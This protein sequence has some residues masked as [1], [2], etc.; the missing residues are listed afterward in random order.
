MH[1]M[2][3]CRSYHCVQYSKT[4]YHSCVF[5][6]YQQGCSHICQILDGIPLLWQ[7]A[8]QPCVLQNPAIKRMEVAVRQYI[9]VSTAVLSCHTES[10]HTQRGSQSTAMIRLARMP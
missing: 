8:T 2:I 10:V 9:C 1:L 3:I 5:K 4:L 6:P 7:S